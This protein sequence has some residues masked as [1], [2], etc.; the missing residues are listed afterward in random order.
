MNVPIQNIVSVIV[1]VCHRLPSQSTVYI[2]DGTKE[3]FTKSQLHHREF[4][5]ISKFT[6]LE[7]FSGRVKINSGTLWS[8]I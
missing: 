3:P 1:S 6:A 5:E 7:T 8:I 4:A 2:T